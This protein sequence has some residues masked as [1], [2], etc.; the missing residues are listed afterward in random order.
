MPETKPTIQ[1]RSEEVQDLLSTIPNWMIRWGSTFIFL[2]LLGVLFLSW[3]IKYPDTIAGEAVFTTV[4]EPAYLYA[5]GS[6]NLSNLYI[7]EG[8]LVHEGQLLAEITSPVQKEQIDY[9]H[10]KLL[11]VDMFLEGQVDGVSFKEEE[12]SF[13]EM[14]GSYNSLKENISDL[15]QLQSPYYQA[16]IERLKEKQSR[17]YQL[18]E[19]LD[20]KLSIAQRELVNAEQKYKVDLKL[21]EE[22][23][24]T[25]IDLMDRESNLN[26]QRMEVQNL[27]QALVQN[28]LSLAGL[29][30]QLKEHLFNQ[31]DAR[32]KLEAVILSEKQVLESF[33]H[34]WKQGNTISAPSN[35]K[36]VF[37]ESFSEGYYVT[38]DKPLIAILPEDGEIVAKIKVP[39]LRY[40]KIKEGQK[41]RFTLTNYPF[42]EYGYLYGV[43]KSKSFIPLER[44]YELVVELPEK[45]V[46]S[47]GQFI[48]YRP[49]MLG[50]AEV[51][52]EDQRLLEKLFYSFRKIFK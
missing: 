3:L 16:S 39:S 17:Y 12:P 43:V 25:S 13:G 22:G 24:I 48:E 46:L 52:V 42:Q 8:A 37:I 31:H 41:V 50:T 15:K 49:N 19:I 40:G 5:K 23:V 28:Q 51:I 38:P 21:Q 10:K 27:K 47:Y 1:L 4:R 36:A 14:Q 35:G 26:R 6:G 30:D 18:A 33:M 9:L 29:Q 32:R 44:E 11:E 45:L 20:Q 7:Q 34:S 2:L